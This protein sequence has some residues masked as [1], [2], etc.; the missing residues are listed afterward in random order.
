[1][2]SRGTVVSLRLDHIGIPVR[3]EDLPVIV[4]RLEAGFGAVTLPQPKDL[5][6]RS[7]WVS[8]SGVE[9]HLIARTDALLVPIGKTFSPHLCLYVEDMS[10]HERWLEGSGLLA[11]RAGT[12][13]ARDQLWVLLAPSFVVELQSPKLDAELA[14]QGLVR[15]ESLE[16]V[17]VVKHEA[18]G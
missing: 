3:P 12:V 14:P 15:Q 9:I 8:I 11:W 2:S 4:E 18:D 16:E 5:S 17:G 1:M 10:V 6:R 7:V 13:T